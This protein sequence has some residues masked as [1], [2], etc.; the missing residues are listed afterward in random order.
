MT[1]LPTEL[2]ILFCLAVLAATLWM[3]FIIGVNTAPSGSIPDGAP[4]GFTLPADFRMQRPWVQRAYRAHL[5]L[6][7]Q[8]LPFAVVVLLLD[9]L[10]AF[11]ALTF[12]TCIAFFW[13]RVAHA[14][15]Y[16]TGLASFPLRPLIFTAGWLCILILAGVLVTA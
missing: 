11:N 14:V 8:F 16:I 6:L 5:N 1:A 2:G 12:W 9:R 13:L 4:D 7:E 3:P 15:G 10:D